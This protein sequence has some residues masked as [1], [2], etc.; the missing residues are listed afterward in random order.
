MKDNYHSPMTNTIK[1]TV[2]YYC[3]SMVTGKIRK[4][5]EGWGHGSSEQCLPDKLKTPSSNPSTVKQTYKKPDNTKGWEQCEE[6][7]TLAHS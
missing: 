3:I 4:S 1:T 6:T 5:D 2:K 7:G